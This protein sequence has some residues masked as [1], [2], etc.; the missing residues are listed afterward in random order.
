MRLLEK[1]DMALVD[2]RQR[3]STPLEIYLSPDDL[4][5]MIKALD[6]AESRQSGHVSFQGLP[7]LQ[8]SGTSYVRHGGGSYFLYPAYHPVLRTYWTA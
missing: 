7:V 3:G 8:V 6:A 5:E 4:G 2:I 1:L